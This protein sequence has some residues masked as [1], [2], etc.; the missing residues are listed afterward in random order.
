MEIIYA[1]ITGDLIGSRKTSSQDV[2]TAIATLERVAEDIARLNDFPTKFTQF[3]GDG[4]QM[5]SNDPKRALQAA[6]LMFAELRGAG[7][8]LVTR[9]SIGL[10]T[11]SSLGTQTLADA[12][13]PAFHL[14]GQQL[15]KIGKRRLVIDGIGITD[16][17]KAIAALIEAIIFD[18]SSAQA[19]IM[20][21]KLW[22]LSKTHTDIAD[23]RNVTR[24]T[25]QAHMS[26]AHANQIE[27][28]LLAFQDD[29]ML[30]TADRLDG[31]MR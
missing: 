31:N 29:I 21:H 27:Q 3:R 2:H 26:A 14:S 4:W 15:D 20:A 9:M 16:L 1:V 24:Q 23:I 6:L 25:V 12:D 11:I 17:H 22:D 18:W 19:N 8:G 30:K 28:A 7:H 10:G 13:G 5:I